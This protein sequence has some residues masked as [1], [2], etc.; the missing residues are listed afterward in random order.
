MRAPICDFCDHPDVRW[1]YPTNEVPGEDGYHGGWAACQ[2]CY[3]LIEAG[4]RAGLARRIAKRSRREW[5]PGASQRQV[6]AYVEQAFSRFWERRSGDP[7]RSDPED[8]SDPTREDLYGEMLR[9]DGAA[10]DMELRQDNGSEDTTFSQKVV[11]EFSDAAGAWLL[12]RIMRK[13][14]RAGIMA[15]KARCEVRV[16]LDDDDQDSSLAFRFILPDGGHR[17]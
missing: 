14:D 13:R 1:A 12:S 15:K 4:D 6:I 7:V 16:I 2:S 9:A 3:R 17:A 10:F 8:P 11:N 5:P